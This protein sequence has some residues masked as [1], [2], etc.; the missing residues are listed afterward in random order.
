MLTSEAAFSI[1]WVGIRSQSTT[2]A[3]HFISFCTAN[4]HHYQLASVLKTLRPYIVPN[5]AFDSSRRE[6]AHSRFPNT[7]TGILRT[8]MERVEKDG[9]PIYSLSGPTRSRNSMITQTIADECRDKG[10]LVASFFF[11]EET[12]LDNPTKFFLTVAHQLAVS[13]PSTQVSMQQ[14]L[15]KDPSIPDKE[16]EKRLR[17]WS[18]ILWSLSNQPFHQWLPLSTP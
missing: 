11:R 17:C 15:K 16:L 14:A 2:Y 9:F 18:F 12:L 6:H 8:I 5:T 7:C 13:V 4:W 3:T 10:E 1:T